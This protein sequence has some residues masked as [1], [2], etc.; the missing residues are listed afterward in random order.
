MRFAGLH[1]R[2]ILFVMLSKS[3]IPIYPRPVSPLLAEPLKSAEGDVFLDDALD[4]NANVEER[5]AK[6]RRIEMLGQQYLRGDG[7]HIMTAGLKGPFGGWKNPWSSDKHR[8]GKVKLSE[9]LQAE[10]PE[11]TQ[12]AQAKAG[13]VLPSTGKFQ[14]GLER[15]KTY[16]KDRCHSQE[17]LKK[18]GVPASYKLSSREESPTPIPTHDRTL[19][20]YAHLL[21][22]EAYPAQKRMPPAQDLRGQV[23]VLN[24]QADRQ[25]HSILALPSLAASNALPYPVPVDTEAHVPQE[26][27]V[28]GR[29][30]SPTTVTRP[31]P[32]SAYEK[33]EPRTDNASNSA[34]YT[35]TTREGGSCSP[36]A[37]TEPRSVRTLPPSTNLPEFKYRRALGNA[38]TLESFDAVH[39]TQAGLAAAKK[40]R[41]PEFA[42]Q[43]DQPTS[44]QHDLPHAQPVVEDSSWNA[45]HSGDDN[46]LNLVNGVARVKEV[47]ANNS[48][49]RRRLPSPSSLTQTS[50]NSTANQLPSAQLVSGVHISPQDLYHS[51]TGKMIEP[52]SEVS[53]FEEA[54]PYS[55]LPGVVMSRVGE[56][57]PLGP[58]WSVT[59]AEAHTLNRQQA[60][61]SFASRPQNRADVVEVSP[62]RPSASD[63]VGRELNTQQMLAAITPLGFSTVKKDDLKS[64]KRATPATA[65]RQIPKNSRKRTSSALKFDTDGT[66][67][68]S[69]QGSIKFNLKVSK[70]VVGKELKN[71]KAENIT[72]PSAYGKL[73]LDMETSDEDESAKNIDCVMAIPSDSRGSVQQQS[74]ITKASQPISSA[75][76]PTGTTM[77]S[78]AAEQ[79]QD[80]QR[81]E[82]RQTVDD[83]DGYVGGDDFNLASAID[84]LGSFLGT[85]DPDKEAS[86]LV[87]SSSV[88]PSMKRTS[89]AM[90][91]VER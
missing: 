19:E 33:T 59:L 36:R 49:L 31:F 72:Q 65:T 21:P 69:S 89:V 38:K 41:R 88:R 42:S 28:D 52:V 22:E 78:T 67:S 50:N 6:R 86:K 39:H 61:M 83:Q 26:T 74:A 71:G 8:V 64:I 17:W 55:V 91:S 29:P 15:Y 10:V 51:V 76:P 82:V 63:T 30:V 46:S 54:F 85:W 4:A 14:D 45:L 48:S 1:G 16:E 18:V 27:V 87:S 40:P 66:S 24:P 73:G 25:D 80:A 34:K 90:N 7:L 75:F 53:R 37:R 13:K 20:T 2:Q 70:N 9:L 23:A 44:E 32:L 62:P 58:N 81:P 56:T 43:P 11:T 12:K 3:K 35:G 77:A 79:L 68:G 84:D 47:T 60:R 5:A 57:D